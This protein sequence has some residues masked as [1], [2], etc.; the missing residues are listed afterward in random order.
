[1]GQGL[2]GIF[3]SGFG[4]LTIF[5]EIEAL[6]PGYSY[7]YLGDSARNPYGNRSKETVFHYTS[8]AVSFLFERGCELIITACSTASAL[9]LRR[10]QQE[11]LPATYP[12]R[13]VLGMV[14]PCVEEAQRATRNNRVGVVGTRGT[15][16]SGSFGAELFKLDPEIKVFQQACPLLV[17]LIEEGW[18]SKPET[19]MILR[20][21]LRPLKSRGVDVLILGCTHYPVLLKDFER[22]MGKNCR[23]IHPGEATARALAD[24]LVRHPEMETRLARSRKREFF[25]TD[26]PKRFGELGGRFFGRSLANVER[27]DLFYLESAALTG[28]RA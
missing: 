14:H 25:T 11:Y 4:G 7:V 22:N 10:I 15:V 9:A 26:D 28:P 5:R 27:A 19:R 1:M 20:K 18:D 8:Q 12:E 6:I 24:Y 21:Y 17:P 3:D 16:S 2:I 13:R 23:V